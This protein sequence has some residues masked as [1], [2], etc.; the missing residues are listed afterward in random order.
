MAFSS[1][2]S[3]IKKQQADWSIL[4]STTIRRGIFPASAWFFIKASNKGSED[5]VLSVQEGKPEL[6]LKKLDF[7]AFKDQLWTHNDG[8]LINYGSK[9]VVAVKGN[10]LAKNYMI[11]HH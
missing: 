7:K 10:D 4:T 9:F 11:F 1:A 6:V 5:L 3:W 8:L 2:T